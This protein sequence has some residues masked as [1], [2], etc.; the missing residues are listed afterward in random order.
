M[1]SRDVAGVEHDTRTGS[2]D[3]ICAVGEDEGIV[4]ARKARGSPTV[5]S[6]CKDVG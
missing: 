3:F 4:V 5:T 2:E 1:T 6:R